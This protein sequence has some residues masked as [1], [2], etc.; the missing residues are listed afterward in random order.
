M[1]LAKEALS[2]GN[3][4]EA[5]NF[6]QHAEHYSKLLSA[7]MENRREREESQPESGNGRRHN[8]Q[9]S[10]SNQDAG[11]TT[12]EQVVAEPVIQENAPEAPQAV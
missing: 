9:H 4:V 1:E 10:E 5:E 8:H 12:A 3:R 7:A 2:N 6:F 11:A